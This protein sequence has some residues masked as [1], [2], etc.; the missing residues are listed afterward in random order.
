MNKLPCELVNLV[1]EFLPPPLREFR[2]MMEPALTNIAI[3]S[4][5]KQIG[6]I[7]Y[8]LRIAKR[9]YPRSITYVITEDLNGISKAGVPYENIV[10]GLRR[11]HFINEALRWSHHVRTCTTITPYHILIFDNPPPDYRTEPMV[12]TF[13]DLIK[14]KMPVFIVTNTI[15]CH[16]FWRPPY[17]KIRIVKNQDD[18]RVLY[19]GYLKREI[20]KRAGDP[21]DFFLVERFL[22]DFYFL[23]AN[24][25]EDERKT[26]VI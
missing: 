18:I 15:K 9:D 6:M 4:R 12:K 3:E 23:P 14:H 1:E 26:E 17:S 25:I 5:E 10:F 19:G 13:V 20:L 11:N 22:N 7:K 21:D 2:V 16:L 24:C 8:L